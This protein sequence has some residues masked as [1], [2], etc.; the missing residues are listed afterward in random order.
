V[1]PALRRVALP[2]E[3]GGWSLTVEP[4]LLGLIAAPSLAGVLLGLAALVGFVVRT[5]LRVVLVD[6]LRRRRLPRTRLATQV[7]L[8]E[9]VVLGALF[10]GASVTADRPFWLPIAVAAPLVVVALAYDARSRSRRLVPELAGTIGVA[11][12]ACAVALAGGLAASA[13]WGLWLVA[14]G[15]ALGAVFF[16]RLQLRRA[17]QQRADARAGVLAQVAAVA[18]VGAGAIGDIVPIAGFVAIAVMAATHLVL[19]RRDAPAAPV[20]GAQQVVLGL[21][22]VLATA[23]GVRVPR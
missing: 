10:A 23:L 21:T 12:I 15:R 6:R 11:A 22:V 19:Q 18:V 4:A 8:A 7:A 20:V 2:T 17:K 1:Q 16:V 13:A 14:A 5:P 9:V 3:H